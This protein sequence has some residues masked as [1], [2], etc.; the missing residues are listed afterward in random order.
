[1]KSN[2]NKTTWQNFGEILKDQR[3][4]ANQSQVDFAKEWGI[5]ERTLRMLE[6]G[7]GHMSVETLLAMARKKGDIV[8]VLLMKALHQE[9]IE[10]VLCVEFDAAGKL[11][12]NPTYDKLVGGNDLHLERKYRGE[13]YHFHTKRRRKRIIHVE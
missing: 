6:E 7:Q 13:T 9:T 10:Q 11:V 3:Y 1:M 4:E 12:T 8:F 2:D 5:S